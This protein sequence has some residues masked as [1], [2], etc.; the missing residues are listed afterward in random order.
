[1]MENL[2]CIVST[3]FSSLLRFTSPT[4]VTSYVSFSSLSYF[5]LS[6]TLN[7]MYSC[8][9]S[10]ML[11]VFSSWV[12][13]YLSLRCS[14]FSLCNFLYSSFTVLAASLRFLISLLYGFEFPPIVFCISL[15]A[16]F[17]C[18]ISLFFEILSSLILTSIVTF[19]IF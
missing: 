19:T 3:L 16:L 14:S 12:F 17:L 8:I 4:Q 10:G 13:L 7:S 11:S 1:M 9:S 18:L 5:S 15:L 6:N 2:G